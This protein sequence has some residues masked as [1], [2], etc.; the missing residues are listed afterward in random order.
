MP[1]I[2]ELTDWDKLGLCDMHPT[3]HAAHYFKAP[4]SLDKLKAMGLIESKMHEP[5][6]KPFDTVPFELIQLTPA[7]TQTREAILA[8]GFDVFAHIKRRAG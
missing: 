4:L 2:S 8:S 6:G 5:S 7:G 3:W 1:D